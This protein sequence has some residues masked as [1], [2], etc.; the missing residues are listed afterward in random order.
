MSVEN[1]EEVHSFAS[2][3]CNQSHPAAD[4]QERDRSGKRA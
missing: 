3:R 1:S 4:L 2:D